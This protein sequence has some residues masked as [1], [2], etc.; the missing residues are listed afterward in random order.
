MSDLRLSKAWDREVEM[1]LPDCRMPYHKRSPV[2]LNG[3]RLP[4]DPV[5]CADCGT[6]SGYATVHTPHIFYIC[7][8]CVGIKG[9]PPG[10]SEL[11]KKQMAERGLRVVPV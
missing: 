7:D 8:E 3:T 4:V 6:L 1:G 2:F 9:K 5:Y 10:L 11:T